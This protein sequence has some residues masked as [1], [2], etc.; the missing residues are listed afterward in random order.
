MTGELFAVLARHS[1][2][3]RLA[4]PPDGD[5]EQPGAAFARGVGYARDASGGLASIIFSARA[6]V[7]A[8]DLRAEDSLEYL[9]GILI[10][11]E[12][13]AGLA[14][15]GR[16][17]LLI[18]EPALCIRYAAAFAEFGVGEVAVAGDTAPAGLWEIARRAF[19]ELQRADRSSRKPVS[20]DAN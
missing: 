13:K 6:S 7:L 5:V 8:G 19:P 14:T 9:S 20:D 4:P 16:P 12:V 15:D 2:L 3:G 10:G 18:G 17:R 11:D 1:I